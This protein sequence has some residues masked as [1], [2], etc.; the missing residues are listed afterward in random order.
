MGRL[1]R[2]TE[3]EAGEVPPT[4]YRLPVDGEGYQCAG[5]EG[6]LALGP[7]LEA[8]QALPLHGLADRQQK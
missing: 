6:G 4:A 8:I 3:L 2:P 7:E 1:S 5:R